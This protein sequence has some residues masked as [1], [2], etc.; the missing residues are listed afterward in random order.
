M[1]KAPTA[2][3]KRHIDAVARIGCVCCLLDGQ[4]DVEAEIHHARA[5]N[6]MRE[7]DHSRVLPLCP[8]HHRLGPPGL[9]FHASPRAW[10]WDEEVLLYVVAGL[11]ER[12]PR[13]LGSKRA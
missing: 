4:L 5:G 12:A 7:R 2:A 3:Q 8:K 10:Q 11:L 1:S 9:A 13:I 6:G